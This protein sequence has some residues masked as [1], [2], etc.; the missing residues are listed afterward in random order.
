MKDWALSE[1]RKL[2][3]VYCP[4]HAGVKGNDRADTQAGKATVTIT[5]RREAWKEEVLDDLL[6]TDKRG[7]SSINLTNIGTV[8]KATLA[9][10]LRDGVERIIMGFPSEYT[11]SSTELNRALQVLQRCVFRRSRSGPWVLLKLQKADDLKVNKRGD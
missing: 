2:L 4:G 8:S 1:R 5:W 6:S 9:N 10:L 7:P 11:S 3:W